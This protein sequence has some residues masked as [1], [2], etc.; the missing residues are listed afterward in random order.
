MFDGS[1]L[2]HYMARIQNSSLIS[3]EQKKLHGLAQVWSG[4]KDVKWDYRVAAP[5]FIDPKP[6]DPKPKVLGHESDIFVEEGSK[7]TEHIEWTK[8]FT[9]TTELNFTQELAVG[10][11]LR[12]D[13]VVDVGYGGEFNINVKLGRE[14]KNLDS[15][16]TTYTIKDDVE[17]TVPGLY[18]IV[19]YVD[20]I[21]NLTIPVKMRCSISARQDVYPVPAT[22]LAQ[23][24]QTQKY[25]K[26]FTG[27][28]LGCHD[29][30]VEV[31]L[32]GNFSASYGLKRHLTVSKLKPQLI[33]SKMKAKPVS[34]S[35]PAPERGPG[36][37]VVEDRTY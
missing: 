15:T 34:S 5:E 19:G 37:V 8:E 21:D 13:G 29:D 4:H 26:G 24:L 1:D 3:D 6:P 22:M 35:M 28:I 16:K 9:H 17:L 12:W 20:W 32:D 11:A 36:K 31:T 23:L 33:V 14:E 25:N 30:T 10:L 27:N 7:V 2:Q 18:D